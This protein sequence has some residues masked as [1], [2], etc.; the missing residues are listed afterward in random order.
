MLWH[1][2]KLGFIHIPKCGGSSVNYAMMEA[3]PNNWQN[4]TW[5]RG[6]KVESMWK[7]TTVFSQHATYDQYAFTH[8]H[9]DYVAQVRNPITRFE[10]AYKH[11]YRLGL[12]HRDYYVW[13]SEVIQPLSRGDWVSAIDSHSKYIDMVDTNPGYDLG[14]LFKP[15]W[16]YVRPEVEIHKL[17]DG[18]IW[19]RLGLKRQHR[20]SSYISGLNSDH[21]KTEIYDLYEKDFT[22]LRY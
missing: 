5:M 14:F 3:Q 8:P 10:S 9:Y 16:H 2:K 15:Q 12:V 1:S 4:R 11:L 18:T 13:S 19:K 7:N 21:V 6:L 20:N 22:L 17:E